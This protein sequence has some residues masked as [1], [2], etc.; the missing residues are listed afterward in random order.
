MSREVQKGMSCCAPSMPGIRMLLFPDGSQTGVTGLEDI[1]AA[2]YAEGRGVSEETAEIIVERL[3]E[4][5]YIVPSARQQYCDLLIKEYS[6]YV[7]SRV[8]SN[9]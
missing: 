4:K 6:R 3:S 8:C 2:I 5:N 7:K 9:K 1:L